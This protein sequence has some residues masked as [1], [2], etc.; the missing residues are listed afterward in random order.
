VKRPTFRHVEKL[1][2][3]ISSCLL[4]ILTELVQLLNFVLRKKALETAILLLEADGV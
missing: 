1:I 3:I 2:P 4:T